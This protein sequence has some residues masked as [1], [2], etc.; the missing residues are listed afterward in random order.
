M[1]RAVIGDKYK[2]FYNVIK[3]LGEIETGLYRY[4]IELTQCVIYDMN[5]KYSNSVIIDVDL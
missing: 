4:Y 3:K 1:S 2:L 5:N